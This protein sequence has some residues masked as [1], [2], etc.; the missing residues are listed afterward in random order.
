[1]RIAQ[2][3]RTR[4]DGLLPALDYF[5]KYGYEVEVRCDLVESQVDGQFALYTIK[6]YVRDWRIELDDWI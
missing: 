1:M 6:V 4:V 2:I 3:L 5:V